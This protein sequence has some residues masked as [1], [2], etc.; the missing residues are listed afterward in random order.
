MTGDLE[1][2]VE[3]SV[4]TRVVSTSRVGG[5]D[6]NTAFR[7]DLDRPL[8]AN[9]SSSVFVKCQPAPPPGFFA[10]EARGLE[11]LASAASLRVPMVIAVTDTTLVLEWIDSGPVTP[12]SDEQLG[13]GLAS[14]HRSGATAFGGQDPNYIGLIPQDNTS[15]SSWPEFYATRRLE[16]TV[17]RAVDEG[18]LPPSATKTLS[19]LCR[20]LPDLCGP[21]EPPARLHGDL[22]GGNR[23]T[24]ATGEPVL[25]DPAAYGGHREVDLAM[26]RLFGG[27][28]PTVFAAYAEAYPLAPG[29]EE[30]VALY[31]LYPVLI[32]VL[33]FGGAYASQALEIMA[34]YS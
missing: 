4:G 32:H 25:V 17:R 21:P 29:H 30:R 19:S 24:A 13:R 31:Q 11:W 34:R 7:V 10:A 27:F 23:L 6:I 12:V 16:P 2:I 5:G 1:A 8:E 22:W 33:L 3:S 14:L 18:R 9:G 26:M 20:R 28:S 15:T